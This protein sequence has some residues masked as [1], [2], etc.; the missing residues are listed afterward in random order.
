MLWRAQLATV[1]AWGLS[2]SEAL[3]GVVGGRGSNRP[4]ANEM[5]VLII[6]LLARARASALISLARHVYPS[7]EMIHPQVAPVPIDA[8]PLSPPQVHLPGVEPLVTQEGAVFDAVSKC[9][10]VHLLLTLLHRW[11]VGPAG[12][13][14]ERRGGPEDA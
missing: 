11:R 7:A 9:S 13:S 1:G 14:L 2:V 5:T 10:P 3:V 12:R 8:K 4:Q 6:R